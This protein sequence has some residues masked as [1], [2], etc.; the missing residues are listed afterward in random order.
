MRKMKALL[1][2]ILILGAL[3][4]LLFLFLSTTLRAVYYTHIENITFTVRD[5]KE[6]CIIGENACSINV[7]IWNKSCVLIEAHAVYSGVK[8]CLTGVWDSL[9]FHEFVTILSPWAS[10]G[11]TSVIPPP[12]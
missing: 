1:R 9:N 12:L 11:G 3:L 7:H 5:I 10:T 2:N 4:S 8:P 6:L